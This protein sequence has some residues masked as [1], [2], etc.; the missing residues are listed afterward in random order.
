[1]N[2]VWLRSDLRTYDNPALWAAME[3][4]PTV[5]VYW[6]T[7]GQWDE[8]GIAPA[9]R[10]LIL[11]HLLALQASFDA[12]NVPLLIVASDTPAQ[13][14]FRDLPERITQWCVQ[15][16]IKTVY[17]NDEYELNER[18]CAQAVQNALASHGIA[19][20]TY[21]DQCMIAPSQVLTKSGDMY[22][23]YTA[24]KRAFVAEYP[25]TGRGLLP[26]PSAQSKTQTSDLG[27][28][29]SDVQAAQAALDRL[30]DAKSDDTQLVSTDTFADLWPVGE[31]YVLDR[32]D[33]YVESKVDDYAESR[34]YPAREATSVLSPYLAIGALSTTQ[35]V[36]AALSRHGRSL[37]EGKDGVSVWINE[38]IWREFYRHLLFAYPEL[39]K[40]KPFKADTDGLAWRKDQALFEAWK[41]GNT[42]YPIVD[43]AMRQLNQ[44]GW[45]HNRL[46]MV[47]AM[48]FT[49]HLFLDWRLGE[50]YFMSKLVDGD[51]ASNNGGWQWSASTGV[52]AA[53]YFRIFNP[54]R[55][56]E[57]FDAD[58]QFIK[59]YVPELKSL[60]SKD[61]HSP[62]AAQAKALK[63]PTPVVDHARSVAATKDAFK[64]LSLQTANPSTDGLLLEAAIS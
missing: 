52:D 56:S 31:D 26:Q 41:T 64:Q 21:V 38:L 5:A 33:A 14:R 63:Y 28:L 27:F 25:H 36:Q 50:A 46:R 4:G 12:L 11:R 9:K 53:P 44:T 47:V 35:C 23:V 2:L 6:L 18:T 8:H 34:D 62:S 29:K 1:M 45:M 32:L 54:T 49:K 40:H 22:K 51:F 15:H 7:Q 3:N 19:M 42:G 39:C 24:F 61:V 60:N 16:K 48:F 20:E 10:S 58:G 55:Q 17:C 30:Q 37:S 13:D 59:R 43:A 57:R